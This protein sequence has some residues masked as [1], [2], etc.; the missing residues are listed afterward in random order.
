MFTGK[1]VITMRVKPEMGA[2]QKIVTV[3]VNLDGVSDETVLAMALRQLRV[4]L[5]QPMRVKGIPS[6]LEYNLRDHGTKAIVLPVTVESA[7]AQID[8]LSPEEQKALLA[9]YLKK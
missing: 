5:A 2:Q 3:T 6:K 1:R 8:A 7:S 4:D 9:R